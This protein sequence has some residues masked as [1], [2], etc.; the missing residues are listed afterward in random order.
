MKQPRSTEAYLAHLN[1][2]KVHPNVA[3]HTHICFM[4][5]MRDWLDEI[6]PFVKFQDYS[7]QDLMD[8]VEGLMDMYEDKL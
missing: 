4:S 8:I 5:M 1:R 3:L 7:R 2:D 6:D